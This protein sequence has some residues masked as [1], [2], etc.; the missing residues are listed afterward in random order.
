MYDA[1]GNLTEFRSY[2]T[3]TNLIAYNKYNYDLEGKVTEIETF[4]TLFNE[5]IKTKFNKDLYNI[6]TQI[7]IT[8]DTMNETFRYIY[9]KWERDKLKLFYTN[10]KLQSIDVF[11][12]KDKCKIDSILRLNAQGVFN[13]FK[14]V[15]Q[16][17]DDHNFKEIIY[18]YDEVIK[19]EKFK[20]SEKGIVLNHSIIEPNLNLDIK[21]KYEFE[22][23]LIKSREIISVDR[24]SNKIDTLNFIYEYKKTKPNNSYTQWLGFGLK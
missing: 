9:D 20:Y 23:G 6:K 11:Y 3:N 10:N 13:G 24:L 7:K 18:E 5:R 4:D 15:Y 14:K 16:Y 12:W 1:K 8:D 21:H 22:N 19:T 17:D 2:D